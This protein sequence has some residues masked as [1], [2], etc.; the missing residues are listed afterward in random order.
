M[1]EYRNITAYGGSSMFFE[2]TLLSQATIVSDIALHTYIHTHKHTHSYTHKH[3]QN[4][5]PRTEEKADSL[6]LHHSG[7]E[8]I[9]RTRTNT[10]TLIDINP[11]CLNLCC[12][13]TVGQA[14]GGWGK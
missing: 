2:V 8:C 10:H 5:F 13:L 3:T 14:W 1:S 6:P 11:L 7:Y 12:Q 4:H 9:I